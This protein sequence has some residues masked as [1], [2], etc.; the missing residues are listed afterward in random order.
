MTRDEALDEAVRRFPDCIREQKIHS[1]RGMGEPCRFCISW[2]V[3]AIR[4]EFQ[5]IVREKGLM[6]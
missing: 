2:Y 5:R 6:V 1:K 3:E 4:E